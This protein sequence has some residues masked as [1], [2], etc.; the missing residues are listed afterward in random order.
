MTRHSLLPSPSDPG[1]VIRVGEISK[2]GNIVSRARSPLHVTYAKKKD[3]KSNTQGTI[4]KIL[5]PH[6]FLLI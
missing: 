5:F 1:D 4:K 6:F 3:E 2:L